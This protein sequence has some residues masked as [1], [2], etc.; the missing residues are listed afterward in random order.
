LNGETTEDVPGEKFKC[1]FLFCNE[2]NNWHNIAR[3]HKLCHLKF[4][5]KNDRKNHHLWMTLNKK[6]LY[7]MLRLQIQWRHD[8]NGSNIKPDDI[9][10]SFGNHFSWKNYWNEKKT[11]LSNIY[12]ANCF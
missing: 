12:Y 11:S 9:Q 8:N 3:V 1:N 7:I 10:F 2:D 5:C 6:K 4:L